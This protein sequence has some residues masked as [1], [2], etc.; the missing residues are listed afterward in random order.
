MKRERDE[1][2]TDARKY[3]GQLS[4]LATKKGTGTT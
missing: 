1:A 2:R 3:E 4:K